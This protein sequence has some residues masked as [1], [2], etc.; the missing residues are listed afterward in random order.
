MK[1]TEDQKLP[2]S[3]AKSLGRNIAAL[4]KARSLTQHQLA[5]AL[6]V[7]IETISRYENGRLNTSL[8]QIDNFA[9]FFNVPVWTLF[10]PTDLQSAFPD[11][12]LLT[13]MRSLSPKHRAT[14]HDLIQVYC[15]AHHSALKAGS[16]R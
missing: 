10:A 1:K 12:I 2:V 9:A 7:E 15:N 6:C 3:A 4:R 14:L 5:A 13:K 16:S 8:D 11:P